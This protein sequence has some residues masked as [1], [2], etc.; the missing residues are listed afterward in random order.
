MLCISV[1]IFLF[2][3]CKPNL[4]KSAA[5][6]SNIFGV[7]IA[8][9]LAGSN[10]AKFVT[11]DFMASD[12]I[13]PVV[14]YKSQK[15]GIFMDKEMTT[16]CALTV[17]GTV[18]ISSV[19]LG[20]DKREIFFA[21]SSS[22][23]PV[24]L[25]SI[26][27]LNFS[28]CKDASGATVANSGSG[29]PVYIADGVIF[30]DG[31]NGLD[32]N[33][34]GATSG[35]PLYSL[36]AA[37]SA[38]TSKCT[39]ACAVLMKGGVYPILASVN[40]PTNVSL[41]GGYDP[42]DWKKRRAD[43]TLLSPFDTIIDDLSVNVTGTGVSPYSSIKFIN[44]IGTKDKTVLDGI[45]VYSPFTVNASSYSAPLGAVNL[46][47]GA[48]I[49]LRNVYTL[50]RSSTINVTSAGFVSSNSSGSIIIKNSSL[51]GSTSTAAS[52][53]RYGMVY[54]GSNA[55]SVLDIYASSL[56]AGAA[57]TA[58]SGFYPT[59]SVQGS[60]SITESTITGPACSGCISSGINILFGGALVL[61]GN[62]I[63]TSGTNL[64]SLGIDITGG[65]VQ[66]TNNTITAGPATANS[67]GIKISTAGTGHTISGNKITASSGVNSKGIEVTVGTG[68]IITG[69]TISAA[70]GTGTTAGIDVSGAGIAVSTVSQNTLNIGSSGNIG[71]VYGILKNTNTNMTISSNTITNADCS[72]SSCSNNGIK[73]GN[74]GAVGTTTISNNTI[75]TGGSEGGFNAAVY[76]NNG[77]FNISGNTI[78]GPR[79]SALNCETSGIDAASGDPITITDNR[80][81]SGT[82]YD[83]NCK[84]RAVRI[85]ATAPNITVT[86][87]TLD[88]GSPS[89]VTPNRY[90]LLVNSPGTGWANGS[91]IQRNTFISRPGTG[92]SATV[93]ITPSTA[94]GN[95]LLFCSNLMIGGNN[96]GASSSTV[97]EIGNATSV[98]NKFMGNTYIGGT[99]SGGVSVLHRIMD[100]TVKHNLDLNLFAGDSSV[101]ALTTCVSEA[102]GDATY[103][104]LERNNFSGCNTLYSNNAGA[105]LMTITCSGNVG[106]IGCAAP[107]NTLDFPTGHFNQNAAPIFNNPSGMDYHLNASTTSVI[108]SGTIAADITAFNAGCG[109]SLDRDG[110]TR[111]AG[112]ALGAFK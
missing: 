8:A 15:L 5:Q 47:S 56:S 37:L 13:S 74:G 94:T 70:N 43:K 98:G 40:M 62:T 101:S 85:A 20:I 16:E 78:T 96:T 79:C 44:Y 80:I 108:Y 31:R 60:V 22:G 59:G 29:A 24:N 11:T 111:S 84:Q 92:Y 104:T 30:L 49:T 64:S 23:W 86:G 48:G 63:S 46:Q 89:G 2:S 81:T 55:G 9:A 10:P 50:D 52:S 109:N 90:A 26:S 19:S 77:I 42:S 97:L 75:T 21:P 12:S 35:D 72:A 34:T 82:C 105:T 3:Y 102:V 54:N 100:S 58:S 39:G 91:S 107:P 110:N 66:V 71:N 51:N 61:S 17:N 45:A 53:S 27:Y 36:N 65:T 1:L 14:I 88:S 69:N 4:S 33:Y 68:H 106:I 18:Q 28:N 83:S 99:V 41:F 7:I 32:T 67:I 112:T 73:A 87:N 76:C 38:V 93:S 57:T 6:Y 103:A 95:S 25:E